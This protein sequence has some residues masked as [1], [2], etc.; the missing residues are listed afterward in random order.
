M[1]CCVS[2]HFA[3][4]VLL[5]VEKSPSMCRM[6]LLFVTSCYVYHR[7][8][9]GGIELQPACCKQTR[10]STSER[11]A[12]DL[13]AKWLGTLSKELGISWHCF[14]P[15]VRIM[16]I[17]WH[18]SESVGNYTTVAFL[19]FRRFFFFFPFCFPFFL[20]FSFF[21]FHYEKNARYLAFN[22]PSGYCLFLF[23]FLIF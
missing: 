3:A 5:T 10:N 19:P 1:H 21:F 13:R 6:C 23:Y 20:L 22:F 16:L 18:F 8:I 14:P 12:L 4:F 2:Y 9:D 11:T 7:G 17:K 15:V